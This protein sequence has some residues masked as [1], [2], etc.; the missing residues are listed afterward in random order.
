[1]KV[2]ETCANYCGDGEIHKCYIYGTITSGCDGC[3]SKKSMKQ[4][5]DEL[6]EDRQNERIRRIP[7]R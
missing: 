3:L 4:E 2:D 5:A 7:T 6:W 1:M